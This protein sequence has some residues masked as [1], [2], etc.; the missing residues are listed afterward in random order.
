MRCTTMCV[1]S[2]CVAILVIGMTTCVQATT[3]DIANP[4]FDTDT[5]PSPPGYVIAAPS[6]WSVSGGLD[7]AGAGYQLG[8]TGLAALSSLNWAFLGNE[9]YPTS[10]LGQL[11]VA[12]GSALRVQSGGRIQIGVSQGHRSDYQGEG[13]TQQFDIQIWRDAIGG[14][15][16]TLAY[17]SGDLGNVTSGTWTSRSVTYT[18]TADDV[19]KDLYLCLWNPVAVQVQ[20]DNVSG[21]YIIPEPGT[22]ILLCTGLIGLLAYAWRKRR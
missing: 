2:A 15:T 17:D 7:G 4:G 11:L 21:M 16:G 6:G 22:M 13:F 19:G 14:V 1:M 5:V 3:I 12:N 10:G 9:L 20:L 8:G 18:A